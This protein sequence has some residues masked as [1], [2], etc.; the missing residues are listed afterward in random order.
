MWHD[1]DASLGTGGN[2]QYYGFMDSGIITVNSN[3]NVYCN[4]ASG[5][6]GGTHYIGLWIQ[7][8]WI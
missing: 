8:Y 7:G 6:S 2:I 1:G 4:L 3:G 5:Y